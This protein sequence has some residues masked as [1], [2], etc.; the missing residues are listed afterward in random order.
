MLK[1]DKGKKIVFENFTSLKQK[2]NGTTLCYKGN[3]KDF[4]V[5]GVIETHKRR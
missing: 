5:N 3:S 4:W 1:D 2:L